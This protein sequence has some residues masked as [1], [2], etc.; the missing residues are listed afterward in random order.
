MKYLEATL[1]GYYRE[2]DTKFDRG[3]RQGLE[4]I[5]DLPNLQDLYFCVDDHIVSKHLVILNE[6]HRCQAK[7]CC[8]V[9]LGIG[10]IFRSN[11][12]LGEG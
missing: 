2:Y 5:R 10:R 1:K 8:T 11:P 3:V 9:V 12:P 7:N 6:I 4:I